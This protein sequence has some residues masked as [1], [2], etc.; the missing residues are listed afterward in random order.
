MRIYRMPVATPDVAESAPSPRDRA[1]GI[2]ATATLLA[3]LYFAREVLVP[4]TLAL[5]LSL[6]LAPVMRAVRGLASDTP[7]R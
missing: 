4:I 1:L 6:L 2:I 7:C 5:I 3:M